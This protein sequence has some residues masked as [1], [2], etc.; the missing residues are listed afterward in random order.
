[1]HNLQKI[2][3]MIKIFRSCVNFLIKSP[4]NSYEKQF[5]S[6][7]LLDINSFLCYSFSQ[8][9]TTGRKVWASK[10]SK[11]NSVLPT[12]YLKA[13]K[14]TIAAFKKCNISTNQLIGTVLKMPS[15]TIILSALQMKALMHRG[16]ISKENQSR[17][18]ILKLW[19]CQ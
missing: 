15:W 16:L 4:I 13:Q 3:I 1:M 9:L 11:K 17:D 6:L 7:I 8:N 10:R 2:D 19:L 18:T 14:R 12:W 5:N